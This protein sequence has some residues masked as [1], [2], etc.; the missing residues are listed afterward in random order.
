M[1]ISKYFKPGMVVATYNNNNKR[2][3]EAGRP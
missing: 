2:E 1:T 3:V